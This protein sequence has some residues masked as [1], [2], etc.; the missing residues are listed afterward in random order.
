MI[1]TLAQAGYPNLLDGGME[2]EFFSPVR[3]GDVLA[4]LPTIM[5]IAERETKTGKLVFSVTETTYTNQ[6]GSLVAK[7]R[8]TFIHR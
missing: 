4:A 5:S 7:S 2:Y 6:N 1:D 3:A 8:Q